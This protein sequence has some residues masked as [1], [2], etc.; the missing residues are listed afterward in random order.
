MLSS[1]AVWAILEMAS[2]S[3][4]SVVAYNPIH[5]SVVG[6]EQIT[7]GHVQS[8]SDEQQVGDTSKQVWEW[9]KINDTAV[10]TTFWEMGGT[11][12]HKK[13]RSN[14]DH[15]MVPRPGMGMI[16][17]L[18]CDK[19]AMRK[20]Q[21]IPSA[22][23]LDHAPLRLRILVDVCHV[24]AAAL[25]VGQGREELLGAVE[26]R[27]QQHSDEQWEWSARELKEATMEAFPVQQPKND[28]CVD[29]NKR[30]VELL[31]Q[32]ARARMNIGRLEQKED[33]ESELDTIKLELSMVANRLS[34]LRRARKA[35]QTKKYEAELDEAWKQRNFHAL[36]RDRRRG[37][38]KRVYWAPQ[39]QIAYE[40]EWTELLSQP[41]PAGG[42]AT[43]WTQQGWEDVYD[44]H[45]ED[46]PDRYRDDLNMRRQVKK[47]EDMETEEKDE[48]DKLVIIKLTLLPLTSV[49]VGEDATTVTTGP[50]PL[51]IQEPEE[52]AEAERRRQEEV[53]GLEDLDEDPFRLRGRP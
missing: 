4:I 38:K 31:T 34:R 33:P 14:I 10:A 11:F 23:L 3:G 43:F 24:L 18:R 21:V 6:L 39:Q 40:S 2:A 30:R 5:A 50:A 42:N 52:A 48:K 47:D 44:Q 27:I 26:R 8:T 25:H 15:Y 16:Q 28:E 37:P 20:L 41:G 45:V 13:G 29:L 36:H 17:S 9:A 7:G 32:R 12:Y 49:Q 53:R 46:P 35:A 19:V 51:P 22:S 1:L